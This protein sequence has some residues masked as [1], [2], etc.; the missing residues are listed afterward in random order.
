MKMNE[1]LKSFHHVHFRNTCRHEGTWNGNLDSLGKQHGF[2]G[3]EPLD[4]ICQSLQVA[5]CLRLLRC[6]C[7]FPSQDSWCCTQG[8]P[9]GLFSSPR[10][11][12]LHHQNLPTAAAT[13]IT[14]LLCPYFHSLNLKEWLL[15][16][17][18]KRPALKAAQHLPSL[19]QLLGDLSQS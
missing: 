8:S 1:K 13:F 12:H 6:Q 15:S 5:F 9:V 17:A 4:S 19:A 7:G 18:G 11:R 16:T 10:Y 3:T 14:H 2:G